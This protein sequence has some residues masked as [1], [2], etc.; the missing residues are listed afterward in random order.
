M[1]V[2]RGANARAGEAFALR[3]TPLWILHPTSMNIALMVSVQGKP[4][5]VCA[6]ACSRSFQAG[7][8]GVFTEGQSIPYILPYVASSA[9]A[10]PHFKCARV[11]TFCHMLSYVAHMFARA[12]VPR[13][14]ASIGL[15][16][17]AFAEGPAPHVG[18]AGVPTGGVGGAGGF[19]SLGDVQ[20]R[21]AVRFQV[22]DP[23][24]GRFLPRQNA[25]P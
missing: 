15:R 22:R 7:T 24:S 18:K 13:A 11:A 2:L 6:L 23:G 20:R 3:E 19:I 5:G 1:S 25:S 14:P 12:R 17:R 9:Y 10:L 4:R 21:A 16:I 8:N